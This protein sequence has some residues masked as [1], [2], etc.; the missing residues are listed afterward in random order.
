[1]DSFFFALMKKI[2]IQ[3]HDINLSNLQS[4]PIMGRHQ[5][6]YFHKYLEFNQVEN[7][8]ACLTELKKTV[9]EIKVLGEYKKH[10]LDPVIENSSTI[11]ENAEA[12]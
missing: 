2:I 5:Q 3:A 1:M 8:K 7:Y 4:F 10:K 9:D 6:Y 11:S 12:L